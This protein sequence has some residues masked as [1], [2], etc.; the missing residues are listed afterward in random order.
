MTFNGNPMEYVM[1]ISNFD[2]CLG[3]TCVGDGVKLSCL[4]LNVVLR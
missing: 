3:N 1:F 2:R 4:S